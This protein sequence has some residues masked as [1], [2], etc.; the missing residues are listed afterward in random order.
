VTCRDRGTARA[1]AL[2]VAAVRETFEE[3]GIMVAA[4]APP[5]R[6]LR[7]GWPKNRAGRHTFGAREQ[8]ADDTLERTRI[9][10]R[11]TREC[12]RSPSPARGHESHPVIG[13]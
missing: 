6:R 2:G 5:A 3:T 1:A 12:G 13:G 11:L 9:V 8:A 7:D 10:D 4:I